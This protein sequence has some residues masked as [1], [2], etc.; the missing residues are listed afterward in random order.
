[1]NF[2]NIE[3]SNDA[4]K[5]WSNVIRKALPHEI[6]KAEL[7]KEELLAEAKRR[8]PI[9]TKYKSIWDSEN[10]MSHI[11][12]NICRACGIQLDKH[13]IV[14]GSNNYLYYNGKWAEIVEYPEGYNRNGTSQK[15]NIIKDATWKDI[16][17]GIKESV[18]CEILDFSKSKF[19]QKLTITIKKR[20][21]NNKL[22]LK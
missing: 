4:G 3:R 1:M 2:N 5:I 14:D 22:K 18:K 10:K 12:I 11:G 21:I 16:F 6:P 13:G 9:G 20:K 19:H 7:S 17:P 15:L 8:Y